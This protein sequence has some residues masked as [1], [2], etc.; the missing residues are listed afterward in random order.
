MSQIEKALI[1]SVRATC[2][3]SYMF[4]IQSFSL[5]SEFLQK[6][7]DVECFKSPEFES[8]GHKWIYHLHHQSTDQHNKNPKSSRYGCSAASRGLSRRRSD[9]RRTV[10]RRTRRE[11]KQQGPE[12]TTQR[13]ESAKESPSMTL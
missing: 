7:D 12:E 2:P 10:S 1:E 4:K 13:M 8:S 3:G 9:R 11:M 5:L 6:S